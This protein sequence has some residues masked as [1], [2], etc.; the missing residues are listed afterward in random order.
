MEE[1]L[2]RQRK[3]NSRLHIIPHVVEKKDKYSYVVYMYIHC[4]CVAMPMIGNEGEW[5]M[6]ILLMAASNN[7]QRNKLRHNHIHV[8]IS[9]TV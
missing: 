2:S 8:E 4:I 6:P 3:E 1:A 5:L 9:F 7:Y